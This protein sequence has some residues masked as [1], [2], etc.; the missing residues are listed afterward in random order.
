MRKLIEVARFTHDVASTTRFYEKFLDRKPN[1]EYAGMSEFDLGG[2][3]LRIHQS[4]EPG[5]GE[6]PPEDHLAFAVE[7][8]AASCLEAEQAG[9][10]VEVP[11][12]EYEWGKSAYFRDPDGRLV[13]F[14]Q[15]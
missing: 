5:E 15:S 3:T 4:Y 12:A 6:L 11:A 14:Y 7:D 13:E 2:I 9:L 1:A 8:L 10:Q